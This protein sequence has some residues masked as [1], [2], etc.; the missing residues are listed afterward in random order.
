MLPLIVLPQP[1]ALIATFTPAGKDN[2]FCFFF[3]K[4]C[5]PVQ[6]PVDPPTEVPVPGPLP[7]FGAA[8]A[9]GFSRKL[10]ARIREASK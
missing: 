2:I 7:I 5:Q 10:R 6:P 8:A 4:K 1:P 3:P 9:F